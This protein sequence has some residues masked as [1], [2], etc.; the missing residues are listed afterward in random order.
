MVALMAMNVCGHLRN[1]H[2]QEMAKKVSLTGE[3]GFPIQVSHGA[4]GSRGALI[5]GMSP[6]MCASLAPAIQIP[7]AWL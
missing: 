6:E 5:S 2:S 3:A 1:Q 4:C 7:A